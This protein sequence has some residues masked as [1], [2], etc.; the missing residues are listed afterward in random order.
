MPLCRVI[1]YACAALS[2][3]VLLLF[4]TSVPTQDIFPIV[5]NSRLL[6]RRIAR[7][8]AGFF[9]IVC[10]AS[11]GLAAPEVKAPAIAP[12][13]FD[14]SWQSL[15]KYECPEWFRDAKFGIWS[16]W[17]PQ[18]VPGQGDWYARRLYIE[19]TKAYDWH[20]KNIGH[21]SEIGYRAIPPMWKAE[22][23]DPDALMQKYARAGAKYF[24]SMAVHH[25]NYDLWNSKHHRWNA[26]E[27]GPKKDIVGL[28]AAAARKQGLRFGVSEH[29]ERAYSWFNTNKNADTKGPKAGV[30]YDGN[31]PAYADLYFPQHPDTTQH[32]PHNPPEWWQRQW[33]IRMMDVI[34]SYKPDLFY[35]DGGIPFG[36]V[37]RELMAH[38]YNQS[39]RW[40]KGRLEAVYNIKRRSGG[41]HGDFVDGVAV[42]DIERGLMKAI[43]AEPWQTD[44]SVADWYYSSDYPFKST[45]D[46][47]HMLADIVS[48]NGNLLLNFTQKADGTLDPESDKILEELAAWMPINGEAIFGTRT[49]RPYG[50][51]P[52]LVQ[53]GHF[54]EKGLKF[55]AQD[56][57]YT[58]KGDVLYAI[59]LGWPGDGAEVHLKSFAK[60][61]WFVRSVTLLG[62]PEPIPFTLDETGLKVK[63]PSSAPCQHAVVLKLQ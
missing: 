13:P 61:I 41:T 62:H 60:Q 36:V 63:L 2:R 27:V 19:G 33:Q 22:K 34:D 24:V 16:H 20:V 26:V 30:P 29:L 21:P 5:Q 32:Y 58:R 40:N 47:I 12:G 51:G 48:K 10:L 46:V 37:G 55:T 25:D 14:S 3:S 44:T 57:R 53:D 15:D 7:S 49:W 54:N 50:E 43:N 23:F 8:L 31:N 1:S 17:G 35:T 9:A 11:Q 28:W 4:L 52:S 18:A 56:I 38:Y 6:S 59:I 42:E 45:T 39:L